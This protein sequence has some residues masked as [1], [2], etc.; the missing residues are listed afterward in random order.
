[1]NQC[2]KKITIK[3]KKDEL[4][5]N[6]DTLVFSSK[7]IDMSEYKV[8]SFPRDDNDKNDDKNDDNQKKD[9]DKNDDKNDDNQKNIIDKNEDTQKKDNDDNDDN[10]NKENDYNDNNKRDMNENRNDE[11]IQ[12]TNKKVIRVQTCVIQNNFVYSYEKINDNG[13]VINPILIGFFVKIN[14]NDLTERVE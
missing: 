9:N 3:T 13:D 11:T 2:K 1:M 8:L 7:S 6:K 12:K 4:N 10:N 14:D 5:K